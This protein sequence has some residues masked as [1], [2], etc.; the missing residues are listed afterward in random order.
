M[1]R[2]VD[3]TLAM[4]DNYLPTKAQLLKFCE[5]M[6]QIGVVDLEISTKI[7]DIL[8]P[9]S[10]DFRFYLAIDHQMA[11]SNYLG[12][13]K[14]ILMHHEDQEGII[15]QFQINDMR[16][17]L[18]VRDYKAY[19]AIRVVGLDDLICH[20]YA[21]VMREI[22][23]HFKQSQINFCPENTYHCATALAI[24]WLQ[25]GG[26]EVTTSFAGIGN[27]AATEEV[28]MG[29]RVGGHYKLN[30]QLNALITLKEVVEEILKKHFS[31]T[32]PII[33]SDIFW[34][35]SGIHVDGIMKKASNYM[36]Y[37]PEEV[38]L[39]TKIIMGKHSGRTSIEVKLKEYG[40][41]LFNEAMIMQILQLV[42]QVSVRE[43]KS[44]SDEGFLSLVKE[45]MEDERREKDS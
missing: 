40:I 11:Q 42:K 3:S 8:K 36:P 18:R 17:L 21:Y 27:R 25:S 35:E 39:K 23:E 30:Q 34:V 44:L 22:R 7:Y 37:P 5:S 38:G 15:N 31:R 20:N 13:Y 6:K 1:I 12:I 43:R 33:G 41:E 10:N 9:L 28:I 45:V 26:K 14:F 24:E 4:L 2:I 19:S 32:K 29:L 16:E